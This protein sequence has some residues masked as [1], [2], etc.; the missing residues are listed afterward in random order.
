MIQSLETAS[1]SSI[2]RHRRLSITLDML[3]H[4]CGYWTEDLTPVGCC[5]GTGGSSITTVKLKLVV[6]GCSVNSLT[7]ELIIQHTQQLITV[8]HSLIHIYKGNGIF[9]KWRGCLLPLKSLLLIK[10]CCIV[11]KDFDGNKKEKKLIWN[12]MEFEPARLGLVSALCVVFLLSVTVF[13]R[14]WCGD[15]NKHT[16]FLWFGNFMMNFI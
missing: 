9:V 4:A 6:L 3:K 7:R 11:T 10:W 14:L 16:R 8:Q 13:H 15:A 1:G 5:S 12:P 2:S